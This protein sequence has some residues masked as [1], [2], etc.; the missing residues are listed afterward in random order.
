MTTSNTTLSGGRTKRVRRGV[1][2]YPV[3]SWRFDLIVALFSS[4]F[5]VGLFLDGWAHNNI[6]GLIETF[7]TPYHALLYSGFLAVAGLLTL[8]HFRNVIN[9]YAWLRALPPEYMLAMLGV[10]LFTGGGLGDLLWHETF[11]FEEDLEAL[12]SPTHLLLASGAFLYVSAP[13]RVAWNRSRVEQENSWSSLLPALISMTLLL[14]LF[15]FFTQYSHYSDPRLLTTSAGHVGW[16]DA[17]GV[18]QMLT[19]S[20][21]IMGMILFATRR[22]RLPFGSLTFLIGINYSLMFL[23]IQND[24]FQA[25]F[26]LPAALLA[27]VVA[28][29]LYQR[30]Q[31]SAKQVS[32]V[33]WFAF[34]VP[35]IMIGLHIT[36][37]L[38]TKRV[39]WE[40]H[41]WA[42]I[43]FL[44]GAAGLLLS[45]LAYPMAIPEEA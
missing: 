17:A 34:L 5:I 19:P 28:D 7:F 40:I 31:P 41:M 42:G 35:F 29:I 13:L 2:E 3:S 21:L 24:S 4:V 10:L 9:G 39:F 14:S 37:L 12:L 38:L 32:R 45:F 8:T 20:A 16:A 18:Q 27:G 44:S 26:T 15:T 36:T 6:D 43:P 30:L 25:P 33:R 23:M 1:N 22:W 11:G